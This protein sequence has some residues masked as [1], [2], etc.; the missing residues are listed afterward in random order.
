MTTCHYHIIIQEEA[1][2]IVLKPEVKTLLIQANK[3]SVKNSQQ[4]LENEAN[5]ILRGKRLLSHF[6]RCLE[7]R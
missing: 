7:M 5:L 6:L 1:E 3:G 4:H 2:R